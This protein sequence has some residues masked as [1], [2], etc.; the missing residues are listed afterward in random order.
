[1]NNKIKLACALAALLAAA[2]ATA[3]VTT[4]YSFGTLLSGSYQPSTTFA[5]LSVTTTDSMHYTFNLHANNLNS[6]FTQ[7]AFIG[8]MAANDSTNADPIASS[9]LIAPG[10][11]GVSQVGLNANSAG[12]GGSNVWDFNFTYPTSGAHQGA[13]RLTANETVEWY[14]AFT[15]P[16]SF[17]LPPFALHVQ[18][19]T[20]A[21]GGSAWYT[22]TVTTPVPEPE[23][24]AMLLVGLGLLALQVRRRK[25]AAER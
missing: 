16:T 3:Q 25:K 17:A 21:Q 19:L 18:G 2:P 8:R 20:N 12:P 7:G 1:M 9:V 13:Y 6:I 14:A 15:A 4:T 23:T 10:S 11:W 24:Y 5:T 22:P